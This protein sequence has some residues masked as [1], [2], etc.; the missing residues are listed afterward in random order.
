M[1][2]LDRRFEEST[3]ARG[4]EWGSLRQSG[5]ILNARLHEEHGPWKSPRHPDRQF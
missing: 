2:G 5:N 1:G 4:R 3:S